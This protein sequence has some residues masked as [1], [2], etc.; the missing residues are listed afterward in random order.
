MELRSAASTP[1]RWFPATFIDASSSFEFP[2][3]ERLQLHI[4]FLY[5]EFLRSLSAVADAAAISVAETQS[6]F[7]LD[8]AA[9]PPPSTSFDAAEAFLLQ[10]V[11]MQ[12]FSF[13]FELLNA[14]LSEFFFA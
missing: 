11:N 14:S 3:E 2:E 12:V 9:P 6:I 13:E 1:S 4:K 10:L 5:P 7:A 8:S